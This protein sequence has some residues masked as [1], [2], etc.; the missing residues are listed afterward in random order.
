[1]RTV[2]R[3]V[4]SPLTQHSVCT[5]HAHTGSSCPPTNSVLGLI[6]AS[7]HPGSSE[8]QLGRATRGTLRTQEDRGQG[9]VVLV[10]CA[11]RVAPAPA[12][13]AR[14]HALPVVVARPAGARHQ[15]LLRAACSHHYSGQLQPQQD[16]RHC[17]TSLP[18][19]SLGRV[20]IPVEWWVW[21]KVY[22]D[23]GQNATAPA[24]R[25]SGLRSMPVPCS[26]SGVPSASAPRRARSG[27]LPDRPSIRS[28]CTP[29]A[30]LVQKSSKAKLWRY[31]RIYAHHPQTSS[32]H[33][34]P[35]D[36]VSRCQHCWT[37]AVDK[38]L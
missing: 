37:H 14:N 20:H 32:R 36:M 6:G 31:P 26:V 15:P 9:Q 4:R 19:S 18:L 29:L 33:D 3:Y 17:A 23:Q 12:A 34:R 10:A 24:W 35:P 21:T 2:K 7:F 27:P 16:A 38:C 25:H 13:V 30:S 11:L 5:M 22:R 1:M 28:T 8:L